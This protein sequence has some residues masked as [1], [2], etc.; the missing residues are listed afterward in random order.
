MVDLTYIRKEK[1]RQG[2]IECGQGSGRLTREGIPGTRKWLDG[3]ILFTKISDGANIGHE[4][5]YR[6]RR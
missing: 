6:R 5:H 4:C 3:R 1:I 2:K